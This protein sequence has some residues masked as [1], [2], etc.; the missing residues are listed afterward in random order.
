[1]DLADGRIEKS[2]AAL[3]SA[4]LAELGTVLGV[5]MPAGSGSVKLSCEGP[6]SHP[7]AKVQ[8]LAQDL[9]W[10]Q[11]KFGRLLADADLDSAGV[12]TFSHLV[13]EHQGSLVE[14]RGKLF[15]QQADGQWRSDPGLDLALDIGHLEPTAFGFD[16]PVQPV[17]NATVKLGGSVRHLQGD[18]LLAASSLHWRNQTLDLSGSALWRDGRLTLSQLTLTKDKS[19]LRLQGSVQLREPLTGRWL[20]APLIAAGLQSRGL[21][22]QAFWPHAHGDVTLVAQVKGTPAD[23]QGEFQVSGSDLALDG[24]PLSAARIRGRLAH[25]GVYLDDVEVSVAAG[26]QIRGRGRYGFDQQFE[27]ALDAA[28]IDLEQIPALQRAYPVQGRLVL[29]LKGQGSLQ[30]PMVTAR[31]TVRQPRLNGQ[32]WPD[33]SVLA[34]LQER[35][36]ELDADLNFRLQAHGR[37]DSGDFSVTAQLADA[38]LSPYLAMAGG[39]QWSGRLSGRLEADGN[40]HRLQQI[41]ADLEITDAHLRYN[42]LD[43]LST[44]H[45]KAR[46]KQGRVDLPA[47]RLDL[48]QGGYVNL[49]GAGDLQQGLQLTADGRLPLAALAPFSDMLAGARGALTFEARLGGALDDL[50]WQADVNL[51]DIGMDIPTLDQEVQGLNGRI[52]IAPRELVVEQVA[53]RLGGGDFTLAGRVDLDH[54]QPSSGKLVF[55]ARSLPLQWPETMDVVVNSTL[56]LERTGDQSRLSGQVVLLEGTYY[57]DVRLNLLS[58]VSQPRRAQT[59]PSTY[60]LPAWLA[61]IRLDVAIGHRYPLLVDNNLARLQVVPDLKVTGTLGR[62]VV[63][64]R[65]QVTE[66]EVIFRR[67]SFTVKRGVV[68]FINPYKIEPS[69]DIAAEAQIRQW[70]V[71]LTLSGT[72]ERL[73]FKL[74]SDP[75][76]SESDIL[77]LILLGRTSSELAGGQGGGQ[78]TRQMLASLVATA[79]GEDVKKRSGVDILEVDTGPET[80]DQGAD[81]IQVTVGKRLSRRLTV[82][83]EVESGSGELVQRAVSEYRFLEHVLASGFQDSVGGYGGELLFRIE[84]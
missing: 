32:P 63:S 44:R 8:L 27:L 7:T 10:R 48:M 22:L 43:L 4:R 38:D 15:L 71:S 79:W 67:K 84:F 17:V 66:G 28:G 76:A 55:T 36:L 2:Y 25:D 41:R 14:G 68:D 73:A 40:W 6:W 18:A 83:Y 49:F 58:V 62:P 54:L 59:M 23:L 9:A 1:V 34:R 24:Q 69:L 81:N 60:Q 57:K 47:C 56:T 11:F 53:G 72:P 30:K 50:Q 70:L 65:A 74:S 37:L 82:K 80:T 64:G 75:A 46:L 33:F 20:E 42:A 13:L 77:S 78:N 19:E 39:A 51:A 31:L 35:R 3:T 45:L 12:V 61:A 5:E 16:W 26:Q 52:R 21:R 29:S